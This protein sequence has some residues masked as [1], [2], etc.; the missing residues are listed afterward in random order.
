[1][2]VCR[3]SCFI[4]HIVHFSHFFHLHTSFLWL[5]VT[6]VVFLIYRLSCSSSRR[7]FVTDS[8]TSR[9]F[10]SHFVPVTNFS[11]SSC[12]RLVTWYLWLIIVTGIASFNTFSFFLSSLN[13][14]SATISLLISRPH[15]GQLKSVFD[16][17]ATVTAVAIK[18]KLD[19]RI[20]QST[21]PQVGRNPCTPGRYR[22]TCSLTP[23]GVLVQLACRRCTTQVESYVAQVD[24]RS[25][26]ARRLKIVHHL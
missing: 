25:S 19:C 3:S 18:P 14:F 13:P 26:R 12:S 23:K 15:K 7:F 9:N 21:L 1:M 2:T 6:A 10:F 20:T 22:N 24:L 5:I 11:H 17:G 8:H 4:L 16:L